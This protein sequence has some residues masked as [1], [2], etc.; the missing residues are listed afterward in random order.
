MQWSPFLGLAQARQ[1]GQ[2]INEFN[3]T[4]ALHIASRTSVWQTG[5]VTSQY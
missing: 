2:L 3:L 1:A 5:Q 4:A